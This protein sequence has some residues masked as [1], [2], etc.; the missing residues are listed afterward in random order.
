MYIYKTNNFLLAAYNGHFFLHF[1]SKSEA[2]Y[3]KSLNLCAKAHLLNLI[4]SSS[5]ICFEQK[6]TP[7]FTATMVRS[8]LTAPGKKVSSPIF[9]SS[10]KKEERN[11]RKN[12]EWEGKKNEIQ[13]NERTRE[14]SSVFRSRRMIT[15]YFSYETVGLFDKK[16]KKALSRVRRDISFL[17]VRW[18][19]FKG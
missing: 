1:L 4:L 17:S 6:K 13:E 15:S 10:Q 19:N 14:T 12:K 3:V 11:E 8:C 16:L 18:T 2:N 5:R 7:P 9:F